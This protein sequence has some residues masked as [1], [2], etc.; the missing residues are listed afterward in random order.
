MHS[1]ARIQKPMQFAHD[2]LWTRRV[3]R[4]AVTLSFFKKKKK[5]SIPAGHCEPWRNDSCMFANCPLLFCFPLQ[6]SFPSSQPLSL[7]CRLLSF[8]SA[9]RC[10]SLY[11]LA[12]LNGMSSS[13]SH[14]TAKRTAP[15]GCPPAAVCECACVCATVLLFP[16]AWLGTPSPS[17]ENILDGD[18]YE[19]DWEKKGANV[20]VYKKKWG[21]TQFITAVNGMVRM[22]EDVCVF[23]T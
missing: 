4:S 2:C 17:V 14:G 20:E 10:P 11:L 16:S 22:S 6:L 12:P 19:W 15:W 9:S 7:W 8:P 5:N 23:L 13:K 3:W 21:K 18:V 1:C